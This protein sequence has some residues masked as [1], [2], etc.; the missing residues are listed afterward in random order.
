[1]EPSG[2]QSGRFPS[3]PSGVG[4]V[5]GSGSFTKSPSGPLKTIVEP[6]GD[7]AGQPPFA[8]QVWVMP[9]TSTVHIPSSSMNASIEPSGDHVGSVPESVRRRT[10][11]PLASITSIP[12]VFSRVKAI[13]DPSGDHSGVSGHPT[14]DPGTM[15]ISPV[16]TSTVNSEYSAPGSGRR[17]EKRI[18][19]SPAA[20]GSGPVPG[21]KARI[22][23]Y[24]PRSV[25]ATTAIVRSAIPTGRRR[26][27]RR[28]RA[29]TR[30]TTSVGS[31]GTI[32][33]SS[34]FRSRSS[35]FVTPGHLL[36]VVVSERSREGGA[37]SVQVTLDGA[38]R[39]MKRE[40]DL[41]DVEIEVVAEHD[42]L[43]VTARQTRESALE[44][45]PLAGFQIDSRHVGGNALPGA[46]LS[47]EP[48]E[49]APR[50][51]QRHHHH[52]RLQGIDAFPSVRA[53]P[54]TGKRLLHRVLGRGTA[55]A[56]RRE[57]PHH[58]RVFRLDE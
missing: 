18:R 10:L 52:P 2:A 40:G 16:A 21:R 29:A 31:V 24:V 14:S 46:S 23:A 42:C 54:R 19:P 11:V 15:R 8:I 28:C 58:P 41:A 3:T 5:S 57:R 13:I 53:L 33:R 43:P 34:S 36:E 35:S 38:F 55:P 32:E 6:S 12:P 1:M 7:H 50:Q 47:S 44:I 27:R 17:P 20:A 9:S 22:R 56:D 4:S 37:R 39:D 25:P 26:A 45:D 49:T 51:V 30:S 48:A